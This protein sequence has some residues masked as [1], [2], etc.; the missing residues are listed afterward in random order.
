MCTNGY[1]AA[2]S[3]QAMGMNGADKK[4][5]VNGSSP[6][7]TTSKAA[8]AAA[9]AAPIVGVT[10]A[11]IAAAS[12]LVD[13]PQDV[14]RGAATIALFVLFQAAA[15]APAL[16]LDREFKRRWQHALTGYGLVVASDFF[17]IAPFAA[18]LVL[19]AG[20]IW[21]LAAYC[22][23]AFLQCFGGLL[24]PA[25]RKQGD[26]AALPGAFYFVLG[27]GAVWALFPREVA[28]YAVL[29]LSLADPVAAFVGQSVRSP[30]ITESASAAGCA[31]CFATAWTIG[32]VTLRQED[33]SLWSISRGALFCTIAEASSS[34]GINDN[35]SMPLVTAL[36]I[37]GISY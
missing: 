31:A 13:A 5:E 22:R 10:V 17:P 25:E 35:I 14:L 6:G 30:K 8:A 23:A 4:K 19:A 16:A 1:T 33:Y 7:T 21:F 12:L 24:R 20:G 26:G 3:A 29:C 2:T 37:E 15:S 28:N 27:A 9:T 36:A 11:A 32:Y 34:I 18:V